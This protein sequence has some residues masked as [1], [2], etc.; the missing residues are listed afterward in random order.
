MAKQAW[1]ALVRRIDPIQDRTA[2]D[3]GQTSE[4]F[5]DFL[6]ERQK[7]AIATQKRPVSVIQAA[8]QTLGG[9]HGSRFKPQRIQRPF[10]SGILCDLRPHDRPLRLIGEA[11]EAAIETERRTHI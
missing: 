8:S 11:A 3:G 4:S 7:A 2:P 6:R 1:E 5:F 9:S 10:H